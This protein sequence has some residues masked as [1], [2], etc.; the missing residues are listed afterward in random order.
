MVQVYF[1]YFA[2]FYEG[3]TTLVSVL[4]GLLK[5]TA[6][7]AF[8]YGMSV[9]RQLSDI[10]QHFGVCPQKYFSLFISNLLAVMFCSHF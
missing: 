5:A 2:E 9:A 3:K 8:V 10:R 7:D 1:S 4:T 6:G